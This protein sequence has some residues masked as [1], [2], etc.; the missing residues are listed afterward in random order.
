MIR[1]TLV[2]SLI[3]LAR[4]AGLAQST[5]TLPTFEAVSVKPAPPPDGRGGSRVGMIGGPSTKTPDRINFENVG[6]GFIISKAYDVK[7]YQISG[8]AWFDSERY[9]IIATVPPGTSVEQ[10]RVMLQNLLADRFML[11]LHKETREMPIYTLS[12]AKNGPK[13][14]LAMPDPPPDPNGPADGTPAAGGGKLAKDA[15]GYPILGPGM[16]M[17]MTS[18]PTGSVA[19]MG[20]KEHMPWLVD[21]LSG[22]TGRPVVDATGLTDKYDFLLSWIPRPPD[23]PPAEDAT[24]PDI[25]AALQQQLGLKLEPKKGPIEVLVIDRAEKVPTAN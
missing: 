4:A 6:L 18:T 25:F 24:G 10:F 21:M 5:N 20:N 12:I 7:H 22:Q 11:K 14:K 1:T 2:I 16:T 8:P 9:N 15:D 13:L 17:A 23:A 19:R 3:V